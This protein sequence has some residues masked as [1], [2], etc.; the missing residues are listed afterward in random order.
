MRDRFA[1]MYAITFVHAREHLREL[2]GRHEI[3]ALDAHIATDADVFDAGQLNDMI[4]MIDDVVDG[5][6]F[7]RL[8]H[9]ADEVDADYAAGLGHRFDR[10]V[11]YAARITGIQSAAVP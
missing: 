3:V 6:R 1:M 7:V 8:Q 9:G 5:D 10:L 2:I 4:E 11:G